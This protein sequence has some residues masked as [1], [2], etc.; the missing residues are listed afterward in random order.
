[1]TTKEKPT[2]SLGGVPANPSATL[3]RDWEWM[4]LVAT[5]PSTFSELLGLLSRS[6]SSTR[7]SLDFFQVT[8]DGILPPSSQ[9]W[10][11]SGMGSPTGCWTL[12]TSESPS[13]AVE[14]LLSDVLVEIGEVPAQS[15]LSPTN[16]C[17]MIRRSDRRGLEMH[18]KL[19]EA[20]MNRAVLHPDWETMIQ[21]SYRPK[22]AN[23]G[24]AQIGEE[25]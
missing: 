8:K 25:E 18:P 22:G 7:T 21:P 24:Y 17:G 20:L 6:G 23:S 4:T 2:S 15:F 19:R 1:M 10:Q 9:V 14:S 5:S 13:V 16:C 11:K 12:N 3:D